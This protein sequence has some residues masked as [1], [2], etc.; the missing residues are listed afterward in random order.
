MADGGLPRAFVVP[1]GVRVKPFLSG[2]RWEPKMPRVANMI[3][4]EKVARLMEELRDI[5]VTC[6]EVSM[7][8]DKCTVVVKA[9]SFTHSDLSKALGRAALAAVIRHTEMKLEL[10]DWP[11][12]WGNNDE[13]DRT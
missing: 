8:D 4:H 3:D 2:E 7:A 12:Q 1:A 6:S 11:G 13:V 9:D 5:G 10:R